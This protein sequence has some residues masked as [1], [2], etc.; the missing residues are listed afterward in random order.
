MFEMFFDSPW[1]SMTIGT[2]LSIA[3][4]IINLNIYLKFHS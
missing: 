4:F 2:S 3:I 1:I